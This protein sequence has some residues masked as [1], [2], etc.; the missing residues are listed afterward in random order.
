MLMEQVETR[1]IHEGIELTF[2]RSVSP[3]TFMGATR[4]ALFFYAEVGYGD[5]HLCR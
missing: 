3:L 4:V 2:K 5:L 1:C